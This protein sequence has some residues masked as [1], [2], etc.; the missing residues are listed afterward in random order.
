LSQGSAYDFVDVADTLTVD[1]LLEVATHGDFRFGITPADSFV[2]LESSAGTP[3]VGLF[4]NVLSGERIV[5]ATLD[6]FRVSYGAGSSFGAS[7]VVLDDFLLFVPVS[8][9]DVSGTAEGGSISLVVEGVPI[10]VF[11]TPGMT[12]A[13]VAQAIADA[14]NADTD[15]ARLGVA[16]TASDGRVQTNGNIDSDPVITD[17]GISI[18]LFYQLPALAGPWL[19]LLTAILAAGGVLATRRRTR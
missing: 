9:M 15:L 3:V 5:T 1:G 8:I 18:V 14:I 17:G 2:V 12:A 19:V 10:E 6:S 11:T 4:A 7:Q 13:E 16:A